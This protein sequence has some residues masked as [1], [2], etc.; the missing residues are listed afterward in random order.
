MLR[1]GECF[2]YNGKLWDKVWRQTNI[3][4]VTSHTSW[5]DRDG[6]IHRIRL[7]R[8]LGLGLDETARSMILTW[9]FDPATRNG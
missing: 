8:P 1:T 7:V 3:K 4:F 9:R 5:L 6:S 2:F